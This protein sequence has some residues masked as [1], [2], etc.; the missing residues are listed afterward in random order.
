[1]MCLFHQSIINTWY[2]LVSLLFLNKDN[3][4]FWYIFIIYTNVSID[5]ITLVEI[6]K[7]A[8]D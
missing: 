3:E 7:L 2:F 5:M 8:T 4:L 6:V 1:M